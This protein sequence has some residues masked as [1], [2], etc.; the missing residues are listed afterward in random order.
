[1]SSSKPKSSKYG[2]DIHGIENTNVEYWNLNTA[3]LYEE[4]VRRREGIIAHLGPLVVRT[5]HHTGRS[6]NDKYLVRE[7]SSESKIWWGKV[8]RPFEPEK[9]DR[10]YERLLSY[11]H[12]KDVFVQDCFAGADPRYRL[13]IRIITETAW[14]SLFA[15]IMFIAGKGPEL[16]EHKPEFTVI[17][18][19]RFH[20]IPEV[21]GTNSEVFVLVHFGRRL[22][23]IGG[24][25]YA[26]E[27]K[28][29]IFTILNYVLPQRE[30]LSMHCSA[31]IGAP[32]D[33][34]I[35]FGLSG[36]GKTTLSA[37][38]ERRLI[39]DDEHGW[40]D[41]GV[42]NFEGGCYAKVIHLSREAEPQI[43]D[44]TRR[45]GTVLENVAIDP[46]TRRLDLDDA[47]L[48]E[49]TRAAY[50]LGYIS[51]AELDGMGD[52]PKNI[53]MLTADAFG[54][55]PPIAKLTSAQAMY[56]FLSGYTAKLAGTEKGLGNEPQAT[57]STCFGAPFMALHPT[58][59]AK[60]L[61]EKIAEHKVSCWLVNTGWTGGQY[62]EGQ[63]IKIAYTRAMV[64]AALNG[65]L[66][67]VPTDA[68]PIFGLHIPAGCPNVPV[69]VLKP[70][71]TW[72]DG[73]AYDEK[74]KYLAGLFHKN[75]EQFAGEV[76][77]EIREAGPR[78]G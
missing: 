60:M 45:F 37:D 77:Q 2:L 44:C 39:G 23:L 17:N 9:F 28:K 30:V 18:L 51:N 75:F 64:H 65:S 5:G 33:V 15:H 76:T 67:K 40:S 58:V 7:P 16:A 48:T 41:H 31:N 20:A 14:H 22:V 43:Y 26:G 24:T 54:V 72:K 8:N 29:S 10:L 57:F 34:A 4:V 55:M 59:Y 66:D 27:I 73:N 32:G 21:D 56:H 13:P 36:T 46:F 62:G 35:F 69:E 61:K 12:G 3:A 49:N 70:R 74:A 42:F 71:S 52:H 6:P 11:L 47:S 25:S 50:P 78:K 68:D 63:R 1:M 38:P 53:I 19:P